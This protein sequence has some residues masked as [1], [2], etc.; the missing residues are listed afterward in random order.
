MT[1]F[2]DRIKSGRASYNYAMTPTTGYAEDEIYGVP[3]SQMYWQN[4]GTASTALAT[5]IVYSASGFAAGTLT[6]TGP[7]VSGGVATFDVPRGIRMTA[8]VNLSTVTFTIRGTDAWG[9]PQTWSGVGPTGNTLGNAGSY[10]DS[11]VTFKTVTTASSG[12][13]SVGTTAFYIGNNNDYGLYYYIGN[14]NRVVAV[15]TDGAFATIPWTVTAGLATTTA[16]TA[17]TADVRGKITLSTTALAN[18]SRSY[19][20]IYVTPNVG[21]S[22]ANDTKENTYGQT[23]YT[24]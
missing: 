9:A 18:G 8:S 3:L 4:V 19:A 5:G 20:F 2:F 23:P 6:P 16:P 15:T 22:A 21:V 1:S 11:T 10:V 14:V 24:A 7:L 17:T 12:S 13:G